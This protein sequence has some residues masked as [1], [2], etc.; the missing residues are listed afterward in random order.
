MLKASCAAYLGTNAIATAALRCRCLANQSACRHGTKKIMSFSAGS[1]C[2]EDINMQTAG[3]C[4]L[5]LCVDAVVMSLKEVHACCIAVAPLLSFKQL[6]CQAVLLA[7]STPSGVLKGF[8][9]RFTP[10]GQQAFSKSACRKR[11]V[12]PHQ[13]L[14]LA[15]ATLVNRTRYILQAACSATAA[16]ASGRRPLLLLRQQVAALAAA[17]LDCVDAAPGILQGR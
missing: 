2:S 12:H 9:C 10:A 6:L 11:P 8:G 4:A 14:L 13:L 5:L 7:L 3:M 16:A 1:S 17:M 15:T